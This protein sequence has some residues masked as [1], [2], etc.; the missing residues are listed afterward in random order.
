MLFGEG[1]E[2]T[3]AVISDTDKD[4]WHTSSWIQ[5]PS[6]EKT[7]QLNR[8]CD[9]KTSQSPVGEIKATPKKRKENGSKANNMY[10][11]N[12]ICLFSNHYTD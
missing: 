3:S 4:R 6:A 5:R 10:V 7:S 2:R 12:Y 8:V 1:Q 11:Y 9:H